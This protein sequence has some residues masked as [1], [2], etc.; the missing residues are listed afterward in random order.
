MTENIQPRKISAPARIGNAYE[1]RLFAL[2]CLKMLSDPSIEHVRHEDSSA[3]PADDVILEFKD[4]IE[5][6][7]AKHAMSPNALLEIDLDSAELVDQVSKLYISLAELGKAWCSLQ[8]KGK[9]ITICIFTNRAAGTELS[10]LLE[11]N[12]FK[13]KF[14]SD[15]WQKRKRKKLQEKIGLSDEDITSF[16]GSIRFNLRQPNEEELDEVIRCDW[17]QRKFGLTSSGVYGRFL[18]H[19]ERWYLER[20]TR[21]IYRFEVLEALQIDNSTL[22]QR[23]PVDLKTYVARPSFEQ[24]VLRVLFRGESTY[25]AIVGTPGSGKSTF[26]TR[27]TDELRRRGQPI[28]RYYAFTQVND[29]LQRERVSAQAFLKSM[30]EQLSQEF[31]DL[32][33]DERHYEYSESRLNELLILLGNHFHLR[34]QQLLMIVDGIDHVGRAEIEKTQKLLNVLPE[35]LPSGVICL[36]G[37]QSLEYLPSVIE[38]QC[39]EALLDLP[40]FDIKQT[41]N[42]LNRY[43]NSAACPRDNTVYTIHKRSEGLPL[44]LR[45]I[46]ES[47]SQVSIDEYDGF[48]EKLPSHEGHIDSYYSALWSE[49]SREP[50]LKKLCGI[51]ARLRFRVQV[52]DLL[53]ITGITD[54]FEGEALFNRMKHLMQVSD[55]GCRVFHNSFRNFIRTELSPDQLQHLDESI[56]FSYLDGQRNQLLWFMYAHRYAETAKAHSYL[57]THYEQNYISEAIRRGRPR[58]EIIEALQAT[59]RAA[60]GERDLVV[61]ARTAALLSHTQKRLEHYLDRTQL[62]RTLLSMG[63]INDALAAFAQE[64]EVYD[65]STET[66]RIVVQ[67]AERGEY[68]FG[69]ALAQDFL[70]KLP[71]QIEGGDYAVAVGELISVYAPR[72]AATLVRWIGE[73]PEPD[74]GLSYGR[75][76]LGDALL[77]K[78]LKNLYTFRRWDVLRI[79]RK[80][81]P[82]QSGWEARKDRWLLETIK[83]ETEFRPSTVGYHVRS[84]ARQIQKQNERIL[85]AGHIARNDL[86]ID[87]VEELFEGI[88]LH[89]QLER[90]SSY[91]LRSQ[92]FE[93]FRAYVAGLK[94]LGRYNELQVLDNYLKTSDSSIAAYYQACYTVSTS[95]NQPQKLLSALTHFAEHE[96][97]QGERVFEIQSAVT[98][99]LPSF[100]KELVDRYLRSTGEINSLLERFR[101]ASEGKTFSIPKITG[102]QVISTFPQIRGYLQELLT[103]IHN[104]IFN[105][106]FGTQSR[107][108]ELLSVAELA[109]QC[110]HFNLGRTWL[111]E[112]VLALRGY[113][114]RKDSTVGL[115]IEALEEVSSVQPEML[116]QRVADI[117]EWNLLMP[118]VTED[119]KG[120][121]WFP[122]SI[123][124]TAMHFDPEIAREL[125]LT[126]YEHVAEWKFSDVLANFLRSYNGDNLILA[127]TLS[128]LIHEE[129][130]YNEDNYKDK[131]NARL[132]LLQAVVSQGNQ[133]IIHWIEER[134]RKFLLAEVPPTERLSF[135]ETFN[136]YALEVSLLPIQTYSTYPK[137]DQTTSKADFE[138]PAC[139]DLDGEEVLIDNLV[140]K[141]SVS[142]EKLSRGIE[143]LLENHSAYNLRFPLQKAIEQLVQKIQRVSELDQLATYLQENEEIAKEGYRFLARG[144]LNFG[145]PDKAARCYKKAFMSKNKVD[146]WNP[147]MDEFKQLAEI[148]P[149]EAFQTLFEFIDRHLKDY[150]WGGET[151]FLLFLKGAL[152]L[153]ESYRQSSIE[154]YEAFHAFIQ[155]QFEHLPTTSPS[156]YAW[157]RELDYQIRNFEEIAKRLIEQVWATPLLHCRQNLVHLLKDLALYQPT[158]TIPWLISLLQH[159]DYTLNTQSALVIASIALERP[160]LLTKHSDALLAALDE[161]HAEKI[162]Y[163]KQAL[164]AIA[165]NLENSTR[166]TEKLASIRPRLASTNLLILPDTLKPSSYFQTQT[167]GRTARSIRETI[168]KVCRGLDFELDTLYWQIEQEIELMGYERELA[169]QEFNARGQAYCSHIDN[170]CIPFETYDDYYAWHAFNRV[171]ERELRENV[172]NPSAQI[173]IDALMRLYDPRFPLSNID[174]K[175]SNIN[176]PF[177]H[178]GYSGQELTEEAQAWLNFER[179]EL[180]KDQPLKDSWLAVVDEYYQR[181]GRITEK[182]LST[183]F[184]ASHTLADTILRGDWRVRSG[185]AVLQLAPEPPYYS[186]TIDEARSC[187]KRSRTRINDDLFETIPLV[188]IHWGNWWHF[189]RSML[190]SISGEW[191]Q[192]YGL[193]WDSSNSLNLLLDGKPAQRFISWCDGFEVGYS[194][195]KL[196]GQGNRL[197]L[198]KGFLEKLMRDYSVCLIVTTWS[199]RSAYGTCV[200]RE[201]EVEFTEERES[202]SV[203]RISS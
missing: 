45:F 175:P 52:V 96:R 93:V 143:Q 84:V 55:A 136:K 108:N 120:I 58:S 118:E 133:I 128:E 188:S 8:A 201:N 51:A 155:N 106:E 149:K 91:S 197:S 100:L 116:R 13:D 203:Y 95:E 146:L 71:R 38:R 60:I 62:W 94:Y 97:R 170:D 15:S 131:F 85:L 41:Y 107:T 23:F 47:L 196:I 165:V 183:S 21:P 164:E 187:L 16:L 102:L 72:A 26:I 154:L 117:A 137:A 73:E 142:L 66:A 92:E 194:R 30:I 44:Y 140:D 40:W 121:R 39:R 14:I 64:R 119:G 12:R 132:H 152:A 98:G 179:E 63:E 9:K 1:F 89:P 158:S 104:H 145:R 86:G 69:H 33:P 61:T 46:S 54:T 48:V 6:F 148:N 130:F 185:E 76:D 157:L 147:K 182:R 5:C 113:G 174:S 87:I 80:L 2:S 186:L 172:V 79:L 173:A 67:L 29:P 160:N 176:V 32:I 109:C 139:V 126:Y 161:P 166:V 4:R 49:F 37:T 122:I 167:L 189:T 159:E 74:T 180:W 90:E 99:D 156:P 144:Y 18:A 134:I 124:N 59:A 162:Y 31:R 57:M 7:Q 101:Y 56:L 70:E 36:V 53:R 202:V 115:L 103:E 105:T 28:I 82:L 10:S 184:L 150:S 123:Y 169:K 68:E 65:L 24:E 153:G 200:G 27:F 177:V 141:L 43:F 81:L 111:Q 22:P 168:N 50:K 75:V 198:S 17:L 112:A 178:A 3:A 42:F 151:T 125:L 192:R 193:L 25:T 135:V 195:R 19:A 138:P 114:Y 110:D 83:L 171:L 199:Q 127:Y 34:G 181:A 78:A 77:P 129:G 35:R 191:I 11:G 163:L 88:I 20:K 190:A